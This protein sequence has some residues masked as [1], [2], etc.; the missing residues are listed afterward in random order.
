MNCG[1][2]RR[3]LVKTSRKRPARELSRH[4]ADCPECDRFA[5]RLEA[6]RHILQEPRADWRPGPEFA[7]GVVAALPGGAELLGWAAV[8]LIP[9]TLA[10]A[11]VLA[12]W[13]LLATPAP[14]ELLRQTVADDPLTWVMED[15]GEEAGG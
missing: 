10:L 5:R 15:A 6:A 11:A 1:N 12:G 2:A 14:S 4:L 3:T 8:R 13:C 9:A 7:S